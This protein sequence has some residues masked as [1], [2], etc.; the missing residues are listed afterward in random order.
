MACNA[1][2]LDLTLKDGRVIKDIRLRA[3][4]PRGIVVRTGDTI[5]FVDY[6]QMSEQDR[7]TFGFQMDKYEAALAQANRVVQPTAPAA[8][9]P[10]PVAPSQTA[11]AVSSTQG[12][13]AHPV[14]RTSYQCQATT[15]KGTQCSRSA[16][17]GSNYC[18]QH[19][20]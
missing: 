5:D 8:P 6:L 18:W 14:Q 13:A 15:K 2:A 11:G 19:Q 1:I 20:R 4:E 17:P 12:T 10:V 9:V 3:I 16:S 7:V